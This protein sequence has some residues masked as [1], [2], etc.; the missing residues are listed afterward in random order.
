MRF[1]AIAVVAVIVLAASGVHLI[2]KNQAQKRREELLRLADSLLVVRFFDVGQ[3]NAALVRTP[4]GKTLLIDAGPTDQSAALVRLLSESGVEK[5]DAVALT[6]PHEDHYG[7]MSRIIGTFPVGAFIIHEGFADTVPFD[8][9]EA[10]L[11]QA[12]DGTVFYHVKAGD[13]FTFD[14]VTVTVLSPAAV[15]PDDYNESSLVLKAVYG[16]TAF[17]FTG[18]AEKGAESAML[19]RGEDLKADVLLAGHHGSGSSSTNAFVKAVSP[20]AAVISCGKGNPYGHP[21]KRV[22]ETFA[23][24]GVN[25]YRTDEEGTVTFLSD[26]RTVLHVSAVSSR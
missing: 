21:G 26:G 25:V 9:F 13:V 2:Q 20:G 11:L 19:A 18:D 12:G 8:R 6:H 23:A 1:A 22:L 24:Y 7:G 5:L 10:M 3:G 15:D 4:G 16:E 14:G 17:L